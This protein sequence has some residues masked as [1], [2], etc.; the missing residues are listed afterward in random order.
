MGGSGSRVEY[1]WRVWF[2]NAAGDERYFDVPG[3]LDSMAIRQAW[4]QFRA[5]P[6]GTRGWWMD[7]WQM[8]SIIAGTGRYDHR[9]KRR[10]LDPPSR[11]RRLRLWLRRA[12]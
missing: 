1:R 11:R 10:V 7:R 5:E 12:T 6:G 9:L 2:R 3:P 4:E 8:L